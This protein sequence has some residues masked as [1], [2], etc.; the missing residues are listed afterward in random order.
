M[1]LL[2]TAARKPDTPH[3]VRARLLVGSF[4]RETGAP[5]YYTDRTWSMRL[6][7][8]SGCATRAEDEGHIQSRCEA[9]RLRRKSGADLAAL[10]DALAWRAS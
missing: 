7:T 4:D 1:G 5:N 3:P 10:E 8:A 2:R 9:L 6:S